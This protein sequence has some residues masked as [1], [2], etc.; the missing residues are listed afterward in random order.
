[1]PIL[2]WTTN[3]TGLVGVL[4]RLIYLQTNDTLAEIQAT[5]YLND[6]V[7]LGLSVS[8]NDAVLVTTK[9]SP[10]ATPTAVSLMRI[11]KSGAN[12][13]L[14]SLAGAGSM[15]LPTIAN[16]IAVFTDT[17]GG[18]GDDAA[19]AINAGNIQAGLSG[20]AGTLAS[21]PAT[22]SRGSLILAGVANTGNTNVT[23]SNAAHA[24]ATVYSIPD[25]GAATGQFNVVTGALVSGN[26]MS[27]SGTAG[28][29][30]DSG[31]ASSNVQLRTQI[32]AAQSANIGGAGAGPLN[33]AVTGVT[34]S[35]VAV[36]TVVSS[37]NAVQVQTVV[38]SADNLAVTL[39]GDPGASCI[40]SYIVYL[41]P[42]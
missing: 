11:V 40:V 20:T 8:E 24:Q 38:P 33:I 10:T 41:A 17:T 37:S 5:G 35:S 4:P 15:S 18:L 16:R 39:S 1:M 6:A 34:V 42:Q 13:S 2:K 14:T 28:R 32:K 26:L 27:A 31:I 30:A 21:F 7:E 23:I 22:A 25:V 9:T 29:L 36:A 19:T 12:T 3:V